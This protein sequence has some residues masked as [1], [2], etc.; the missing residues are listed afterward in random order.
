MAGGAIVM[1][2]LLAYVARRAHE[3]SE[4]IRQQRKAVES[5]AGAKKGAK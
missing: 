1:P 2:E 5:R 4:I 3:E